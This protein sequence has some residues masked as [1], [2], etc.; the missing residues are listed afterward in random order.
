MELANLGDCEVSELFVN[1]YNKNMVYCVRLT[2]STGGGVQASAAVAAADSGSAGMLLDDSSSMDAATTMNDG[3]C[4]LDEPV[5]P[6][7]QRQKSSDE[8]NNNNN[9]AKYQSPYRRRSQRRGLAATTS[10]SPHVAGDITPARSADGESYTSAKGRRGSKRNKRRTTFEQDEMDALEIPVLVEVDEKATTAEQL[11]T[12]RLPKPRQLT[13]YEE[14]LEEEQDYLKAQ[15]L[16]ARHKNRK[17]NK[18]KLVK[19][20]KLAVAA[21]AT[22]GVAVV[23]AGIGLVAGLVFLG[24]AVAGG[25]SA[26]IGTIAQKKE[27][28][29]VIA[30]EDYEV[31]KAWKSCLD[32]A[33]ESGIVNSSKWGQFFATDGRKARL[34]LLRPNPVDAERKPPSP[35]KGDRTIPFESCS[36]WV[37]V[38][39]GWMNL[40]G[41]GVQA[42]RIFREERRCDS[43]EN[44][45]NT[46]VTD[47]SVAGKP[48]A[49]VK[50]Q[51]VLSSSPLNAFLCLMSCGASLKVVDGIP[52][53]ESEYRSSFRIIESLDN[54]SDIIHLVTRPL[55]LF[56]Y[57]TVPRDYVL[58]RYWRLEP[59]GRYIVCYES[60][61][62]KKCPP[63]QNHVRAEMHQVFTIAPPKKRRRRRSSVNQ[64][65]CLMTAVVQVDPKGWVPTTRWRALSNQSYGDAF[66]ISALLQLLEIR[67]A[68]D[69]DRFMPLSL[70][71]SEQ[72]HQKAST[73][74]SLKGVENTIPQLEIPQSPSADSADETLMNDDFADYDYSYACHELADVS[75]TMSGLMN[76]PLPYDRMS[77]AEPDSN[78][79]RVRGKYYLEDRKKHNAGPS[80]GRLI[81]VDLVQVDK[82]I[83]SGFTKHPTERVQLALQREAAHKA[84]GSKS[85]VPPFIYVV[86]IVLPGPP[87]YHGVFYYAVDDMSTIDGSDGTPSS[88]LCKKFFF[89]DSDAFR[90]RTFKLIPQIVQGNFL[91]RR[92]VGSTP[93]IIGKK[94]RQLYVRSDRFFEL[95]MDCGSSPV[96]AGVV[97]V[98][99]GYARSLVVDMAFLFE[100]VDSDTL[101]ERIFG[102]VRMKHPNFGRHVRFVKCPE[103]DDCEDN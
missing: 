61:E 32:A 5:S 25:G 27:G 2:W 29:L 94:L 36:K 62:H 3:A 1:R 49:P 91:V 13:P 24:A 76:T 39:G 100:A 68:I 14:E 77:W 33:V 84:R 41:C 19:G 85:D 52:E 56:P 72:S 21:G 102:C 46:I 63:L 80:I 20:T 55:Y 71:Q 97:R 44:Q 53:I 26:M 40:L 66:G 89:G 30:C 88:K 31:A 17:K 101:P 93:A 37:P 54:N 70:D 4:L 51:V 50:A 22:V 58:F 6:T 67:D 7:L 38:E 81:A 43:K 96:A 83:Y 28:E 9:A 75:N 16:T 45:M 79:F 65:E 60:V 73:M 10:S 86:N 34:A 11:E 82:P 15:Y 92:A 64:N 57:W 48:C 8:A 98:S 103:D 59:D 87:F 42:L 99:L 12:S 90:D 47:I 69:V 74:F 95:I 23:T 78:S 18:Q 35:A